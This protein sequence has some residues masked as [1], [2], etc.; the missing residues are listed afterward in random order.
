MLDKPHA[1]VV[2][3]GYRAEIAPA[4]AVLFMSLLTACSDEGTPAAASPPAVI[5]MADAPGAPAFTSEH[6]PL[7]PLPHLDP[8]RVELGRQLFNDVRL[9]KSGTLACVTCHNP[10]SGGIDSRARSPAFDGKL[11][12]FNTPTIFNAAYNFRIFWNGRAA[13][14]EEQVT[15]ERGLGMVWENAPQKIAA[16]PGYRKAFAASYPDGL[17][18]PNIVNAIV[19]YERTLVTPNSPFDKHLRGDVSALTDKQKEGYRLFKQYGC[20]SCHQGV[21]LG[22]NLYQKL[23]VFG[24]W[25]AD[26]GGPITTA[27]LGRYNVTYL[28]EDRHVFRVPSL[29]NV[30]ITAPYFHDGSIDTL[31]R[32]VLAMSEH[33]LGR[34]LSPKETENIV[35]FL[36]SLTGEYQGKPLRAPR[37]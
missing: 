29:R 14:L 30:A 24:D 27:D 1:T 4:L 18:L 9:S 6:A 34:K 12:A 36:D 8:G 26:R 31:P 22:G 23:G 2:A 32:A 25:F 17:T 28:E 13:T 33:Q 7:P 10:E 20:A 15:E 5:R 19:T 37:P 16:L 21:N 35:D 3:A 11:T